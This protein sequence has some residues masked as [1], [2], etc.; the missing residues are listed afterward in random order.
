MCEGGAAAANLTH[1]VGVN[2]H[3]HPVCGGGAAAANLTHRVGVT[4][5][6]WVVFTPARCAETNYPAGINL[7][8]WPSPHSHHQ[9]SLVAEA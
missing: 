9:C 5:H 4:H 6:P 1:Q 8:Q 3:P 7:G 2:F